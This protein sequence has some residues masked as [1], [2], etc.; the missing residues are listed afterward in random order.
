MYAKDPYEDKYQLLINERESPGLKYFNDP[1]VFSK[2]SNDMQ[3]VYKILI[4]TMSIKNV[5]Y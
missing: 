3:N 5:K 4:N 1:K 2:Y